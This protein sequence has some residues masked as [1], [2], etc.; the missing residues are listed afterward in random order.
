MESIPAQS[1]VI[2]MSSLTPPPRLSARPVL[3]ARSAVDRA[4]KWSYVTRN[5]DPDDVAF[6]S[7]QSDHR[8]APGD[9]VIARVTRIAQHT[10]VQLRSGRRS[11]LFPGDQLVLAYGHRYA[12]DQF[13]AEVPGDLSPCHLVAAGGIAANALSKRGNLKWPTELLPDGYLMNA[14]G[15]IMNLRDYVS[16]STSSGTL[17]PVIC[18]AGTS[19]NAGKTT[20]VASLAKGLSQA[21]YG[22]AALKVTGTGAGNDAWAY[23]DAG[24]TLTLD[25]T[26]AGHASTYK[27]GAAQI[28]QCL[29][30]LVARANA[31]DRIDVVL[32]EIAD[33]LLHHE[34]LELLS[35]DTYRSLAPQLIFA[36]GEAMGALAGCQ[37]LNQCNVKVT[38]ISGLLTAS[39]LAAREAESAT[40]IPVWNCEML[41]SA[42]IAQQLL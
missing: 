41:Q 21:G 8:P 16:P 28:E 3:Q 18:V 2:R 20:T 6:V 36:A 25:F 37:L 29:A 15:R 32:I 42:G 11:Q 40:R 14:D 38:A 7:P 39:E 17:K 12:P 10:K 19:M 4:A 33:G 24:A 34:T 13:E 22:V 26:D 1:Q 5:V 35:S 31:D 27:L 23:I 30:Y 9:L